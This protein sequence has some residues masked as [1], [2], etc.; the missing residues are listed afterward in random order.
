VEARH[1]KGIASQLDLDLDDLSI[2]LACLSFVS[3]A[4]DAGDQR[5]VRGQLIRMTPDLWA[6]GLALPARLALKRAC[7]RGIPGAERALADVEQRG[8]RSLTA[9][10]IVYRLAADLSARAQG[11]MFKMGF[12]R[13]PP[14][15]LD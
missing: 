13:W 9:Q 1:A 8:G 6:E 10:A 12:Q 15:D 4:I 11:D 3:M 14:A 7:K 5:A 2:C